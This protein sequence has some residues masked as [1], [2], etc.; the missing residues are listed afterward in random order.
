MPQF[1]ASRWFTALL[2]GIVASVFVGCVIAFRAD[3]AKISFSAL[4]AAAGALAL[5]A[6]LSLLNYALRG[7]R[8]T[9]YF[10]HIGYK[11]PPVYAGLTYLAGFAFALS[12]GKVGE[13]VRAAYYRRQGVPLAAV[14]AV[15]FC[16]KLTDLAVMVTLALI[17]LASGA[18]NHSAVLWAAGLSIPLAVLLIAGIKKEH[19]ARF[20]DYWRGRPGKL[21]RLFHLALEGISS[22]KSLLTPGMV[23]LGLLLGF[24]AWGAEGVGLSVLGA[25]APS[26]AISMGQGIGIYAVAI[27]V[28]ALSFLPG[29]LGTAEAVMIALLVHHGYALQDALLMTLACRILTLWF[30][31][32]LGWLAVGVLKLRGESALQ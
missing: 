23:A 15:F 10:R 8:W 3:L 7:W 14:T 5:T 2:Y 22:T 30:A 32:G 18:G 11:L 24:I 28:G 31:I 6:G 12:P 13:M 17:F 16:E 1:L 4:P 9:L 26:V 25:L 19:L 27:V 20:D 29:G 21:A